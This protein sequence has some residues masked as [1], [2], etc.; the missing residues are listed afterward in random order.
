VGQRGK[1]GLFKNGI[2]RAILNGFINDIEERFILYIRSLEYRSRDHD[3]EVIF[4]YIAIS[5]PVEKDIL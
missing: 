3:F 2:T 5:Q 1:F 4:T